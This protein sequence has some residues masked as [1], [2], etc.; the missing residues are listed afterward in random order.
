MMLCSLSHIRR[1]A[2]PAGRKTTRAPKIVCVS[3]INRL[4]NRANLALAIN[5]L[6][7]DASIASAIRGPEENPK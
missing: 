2:L 4:W 7:I 6:E 5:T 3:H 1:T